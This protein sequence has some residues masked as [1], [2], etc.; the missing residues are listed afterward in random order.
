MS[1]CLAA[2]LML[3]NKLH[4]KASLAAINRLKWLPLVPLFCVCKEVFKQQYTSCMKV[5]TG[6]Y[7]G[8][9]REYHKRLF[10]PLF[11]PWWNCTLMLGTPFAAG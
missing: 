7:L 8:P 11:Y 4:P 6:G 5:V 2:T 3:M 1:T 10:G 9:I